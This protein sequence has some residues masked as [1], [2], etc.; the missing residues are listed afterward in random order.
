MFNRTLASDFRMLFGINQFFFASH[1]PL[2]AE[3]KDN[4]FCLTRFNLNVLSVH[5]DLIYIYILE[6]CDLVRASRPLAFHFT[7]L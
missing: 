5:H 3:I 1:L 4:R 6:L 7:K 2:D